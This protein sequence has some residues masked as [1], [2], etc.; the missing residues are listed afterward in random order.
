MENK[1]QLATQN[2][3]IDMDAEVEQYLINRMVT[4]TSNVNPVA[5]NKGTKGTTSNVNAATIPVPGKSDV[6]GVGV[7]AKVNISVMLDFTV[8]CYQSQ[9]QGMIRN[10]NDSMLSILMKQSNK[11]KFSQKTNDYKTKG[12]IDFLLSNYSAE[13]PELILFGHLVGLQ[14]KFTNRIY[15]GWSQI[16]SSVLVP[17]CFD[18][19]LKT[20]ELYNEQTTSSTGVNEFRTKLSKCFHM[21]SLTNNNANN[22]AVNQLN[23]NN[24]KVIPLKKALKIVQFLSAIRQ[25][26]WVMAPLIASCT[27]Y[28]S[29][30]AWSEESMSKLINI[31]F[32]VSLTETNLFKKGVN[33]FPT[34]FESSSGNKVGL[35]ASTPGPNTTSNAN[36]GLNNN[37]NSETFLTTGQTSA[38][39]AGTATHSR[40]NSISV[41]SAPSLTRFNSGLSSGGGE[42]IGG[43]NEIPS[44]NN[45]TSRGPTRA[46]SI[47]SRNSFNEG[48]ARRLSMKSIPESHSNSRSNL[49]SPNTPAGSR[50]RKASNFS[51]N[52]LPNIKKDVTNNFKPTTRTDLLK[53]LNPFSEKFWKDFNQKYSNL[54]QKVYKRE[55]SPSSPTKKLMRY[56]SSSVTTL[57]DY[58]TDLGVTIGLGKDSCY[59][60]LSLEESM[61]IAEKQNL[62]IPIT[63]FLFTLI[64]CWEKE[65]QLLQFYLEKAKLTKLR[66]PAITSNYALL[67]KQRKEEQEAR[68]GTAGFPQSQQSQDQLLPPMTAGEKQAI[69]KLIFFY[70]NCSANKDFL[71]IDWEEVDKNCNNG[72]YPF[73]IPRTV[74]GKSRLELSVLTDHLIKIAKQRL[75]DEE[76]EIIER[77][78]DQQNVLLNYQLN[79]KMK[80]RLSNHRDAYEM[81]ELDDSSIVTPPILPLM[82]QNQEERRTGIVSTFMNQPEREQENYA[83]KLLFVS[84]EE[85]NR[86]F[87]PPHRKVKTAD[88]KTLMIPLNTS[89]ANTKGTTM[90]SNWMANQSTLSVNIPNHLQVD[91]SH[92][93]LS[94]KHDF[95]ENHL[96]ESVTAGG[97]TRG[98]LS[99]QP[100]KDMAFNSSNVV[101]KLSTDVRL[102]NKAVNNPKNVLTMVDVVD[103]DRR[104]LNDSNLYPY[105]NEPEINKHFANQFLPPRAKTALAKG[106][107]MTAAAGG[108]SVVAPQKTANEAIAEVKT[109]IHDPTY[110]ET[111]EKHR[112]TRILSVRKGILSRYQ[113]HRNDPNYES[114]ESDMKTTFTITENRPSTAPATGGGSSGNKNKETAPPQKV[115]FEFTNSDEHINEY[116][117]PKDMSWKNRII[118]YLNIVYSMNKNGDLMSN[119]SDSLIAESSVK[120]LSV[121]NGNATLNSLDIILKTYCKEWQLEYMKILQLMGNPRLSTKGA[122]LVGKALQA[123]CKLIHLNLNGMKIGDGG[124]KS[125]LEGIIEGGGEKHMIRMDLKEN[126]ITIAMNTFRLVGRLINLKFLDLG[127]NSFTL[128]K[129]SQWDSFYNGIYPLIH[130]KLEYF[131]LA[132]NKIQDNGFQR[133]VHD[134]I[135]TEDSI[136]YNIPLKVLDVSHCFITNRS[137]YEIE[138]ILVNSMQLE[139]DGAVYKKAF[140]Y[141]QRYLSRPEF[142]DLDSVTQNRQKVNTDTTVSSA[143]GSRRLSF[144]EDLSS[145]HETYHRSKLTEQNISRVFFKPE[146]VP[147][148][149]N[150]SKARRNATNRLESRQLHHQ[151]DISCNNSNPST[152]RGYM[153]GSTTSPSRR[154]SSFFGTS[155]DKMKRR[156]SL[157]DSF[158]EHLNTI[159]YGNENLILLLNNIRQQFVD[160]N[161]PNGGGIAAQNSPG[162][163]NGS[164]LTSVGLID[165]FHSLKIN[166]YYVLT[167]LQSLFFHGNVITQDI[168]DEIM[169]YKHKSAVQLLYHEDEGL[170]G[171][172]EYGNG[173]EDVNCYELSDYQIE[174]HAIEMAQL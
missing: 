56:S 104:A 132:Y 87:I 149:V 15:P 78:N 45:S 88:N 73:T 153:P 8:E 72:F 161:T 152:P 4:E 42:S 118:P 30:L 91:A 2:I 14:P 151:D 34:A 155:P 124:L 150:I 76:N 134:I 101:G 165:S 70:R 131:S 113:S 89:T 86:Q 38:G 82:L 62:F 12:L 3:Q 148:Y 90:T 168:W 6:V 136:Y 95:F 116:L 28:E 98:I 105:Q 112:K 123:N 48:N 80:D 69:T 108:G 154:K 52:S 65:Y 160:N 71:G 51:F 79:Q 35:G 133:I 163:K 53:L 58:L 37:N 127:K 26:Y 61:E 174:L 144:A 107:P 81:S 77:E 85:A 111:V 114:F 11:K 84:L 159:V 135:L 119:L 93:P 10:A 36:N 24:S 97:F 126:N 173:I 50:P 60:P 170:D 16:I 59:V 39:G 164:N 128:D 137:K 68:Q 18:S 120:Y 129:E 142:D 143:S 32:Y 57:L 122:E 66:R 115:T 99:P 55:E 23:Q 33:L 167:H 19:C 5:G 110:Y 7:A 92:L 67:F 100:T 146:M 130:S 1:L 172:I 147:V 139:S 54:K 102:I 145:S 138:L 63:D 75:L 106:R 9:W 171:G 31:L 22:P 64:I 157:R 40:A 49:L 47:F 74:L 96:R 43:N 158:T 27:E 17:L 162:S 44:L 41:H 169:D 125:I 46:N 117:N 140:E 166:S 103:Q 20:N 25:P 29:R 121:K 141:T 109:L 94:Q 83:E 156:K 13:M 21:I